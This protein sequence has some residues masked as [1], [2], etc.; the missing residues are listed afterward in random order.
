M[1]LDY[2]IDGEQVT[3]HTFFKYLED[4]VFKH[5]QNERHNWECSEDYYDYVK[6]K[7]KWRD[8]IKL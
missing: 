3:E 1:K 8:R 2:Y 4:N 7:N 6:Q 5:C